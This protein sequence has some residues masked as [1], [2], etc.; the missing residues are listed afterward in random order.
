MKNYQWQSGA[1]AKSTLVIARRQLNHRDR[2][3]DNQEDSLSEYILEERVTQGVQKLQQKIFM[4]TF[5][6][7]NIVDQPV[8]F[9][10]VDKKKTTTLQEDV[11]Q[12]RQPAVQD[13]RKS[14]KNYTTA[15]QA[16][17]SKARAIEIPQELKE[18]K[19]ALVLPTQRN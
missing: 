10:K 19:S 9:K 8:K 11:H 12:G 6:F 18:D 7:E 5:K 13:N 3:E 16:T 2:P 15:V 1:V 17:C 14:S 4:K